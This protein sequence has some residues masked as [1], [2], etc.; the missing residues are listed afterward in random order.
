MLDNLKEGVLRPEVHD[1]TLNPLY[2]AVLAHYGV[3]ALPCCVRHPDRKGKTESSIRHAQ[4][5][6]RGLRFEAAA[7]AQLYLA[8]WETRWADTRIHGTTKRQVQQM[9]EDFQFAS[10]S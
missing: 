1:P 3:T 6:L 2:R 7:E 10:G 5:K 9:Y 8:R 4:Q